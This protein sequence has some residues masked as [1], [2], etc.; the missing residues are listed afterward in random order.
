MTR[1]HMVWIIRKVGYMS[2]RFVRLQA[3]TTQERHT[4]INQVREA[5]T[6]SGGIILDFKMFSNRSINFVFEISPSDV[7]KLYRILQEIELKLWQD[8]NDLPIISD[9]AAVKAKDLHGTLQ[10]T[11]IHGDPDLRIEVPPFEL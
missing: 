6:H 9:D 11:F 1:N 5:I 2:A 7:D 8:R 10:I 4:V 3:S